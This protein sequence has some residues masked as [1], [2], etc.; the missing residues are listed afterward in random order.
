[1]DWF[2]CV[3]VSCVTHFNFLPQWW[4][5]ALCGQSSRRG[6]VQKRQS[7][8]LTRVPKWKLFACALVLLRKLGRN[9]AKKRPPAAMYWKFWWLH[10]NV[11]FSEKLIACFAVSSL[12]EINNPIICNPRA[13]FCEWTSVWIQFSNEMW[14]RSLTRA[15]VRQLCPKALFSFEFSYAWTTL[16]I[17]HCTMN[18]WHVQA[19]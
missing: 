10:R 5:F 2:V 19:V 8:I 1:M 4:D 9:Q 13:Y 7:K 3:R 11:R 17:S 14:T 15:E 6:V 12:S 18:W 16:N